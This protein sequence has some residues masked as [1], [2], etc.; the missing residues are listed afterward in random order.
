MFDFNCVVA[1]FQL[2]I[3]NVHYSTVSLPCGADFAETPHAAALPCRRAAA[4][5]WRR[6]AAQSRFVTVSRMSIF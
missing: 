4:Q 1:L 3:F 2:G 5:P 6:A